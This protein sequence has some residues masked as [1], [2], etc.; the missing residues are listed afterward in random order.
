MEATTKPLKITA[1]TVNN[2][3]DRL[4]AVVDCH[5]TK[6]DK[7]ETFIEGNGKIGAK[8]I[9]YDMERRVSNIERL[10][11]VIAGGVLTSLIKLFFGT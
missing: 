11:W 1:I 8:T 6:L 3:V 5:D 4:E 10:T 9:I 2:R 7:H